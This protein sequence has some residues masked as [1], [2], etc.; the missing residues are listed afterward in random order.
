VKATS[1][2]R[3]SISKSIQRQ[4]GR[5]DMRRAALLAILLL[6]EN[7]SPRIIPLLWERDVDA[8]HVRD[9]GL[10]SA[11]DHTLWKLALDETRTIVTINGKDFRKLAQ[12]TQPHPGVVVI[13]SGGSADAQ[14]N[15]IMSA[16]KWVAS[17]N[18]SG[19]FA[20]RYLEVNEKGEIIV[21][22]LM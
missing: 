13:P 15:F 3:G 19:G 11:P 20:N 7:T 18:S 4:A 9:R 12:R 2:S 22:E 14:L 16:V 5:R 10:L 17:T 1:N 21:A 6:D 8:V